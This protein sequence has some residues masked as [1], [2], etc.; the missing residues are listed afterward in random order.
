MQVIKSACG[1][2]LRKLMPGSAVAVQAVGSSREISFET[3]L[4]LQYFHE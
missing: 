2:F 4:L 3:T 1:E